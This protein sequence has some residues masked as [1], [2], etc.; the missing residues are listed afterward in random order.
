M[1]QDSEHVQKLIAARDREVARPK[2]RAVLAFRFRKLILPRVHGLIIAHALPPPL[3]A[4]LV[5]RRNAE[6]F[7]RP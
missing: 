6:L 2:V 1:T 5:S 7:H 4:A 3:P